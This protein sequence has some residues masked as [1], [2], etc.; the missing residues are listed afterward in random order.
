MWVLRRAIGKFERNWNY[1]VG[2]VSVAF[3]ITAAQIYPIVKYA[4]GHGKASARVVVGGTP[5]MFAHDRV[6]ARAGVEVRPA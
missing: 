5:V 3:A 4:L 1:D 2:L 6:P